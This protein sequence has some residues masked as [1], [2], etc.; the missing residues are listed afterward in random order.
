MYIW[1]AEAWDK[2]ALFCVVNMLMTK[3]L[4]EIKAVHT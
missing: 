4:I 2:G 1:H 3:C